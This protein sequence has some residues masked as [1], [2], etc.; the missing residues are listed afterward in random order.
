MRLVVMSHASMPQII[1]VTVNE[2]PS[3]VLVASSPDLPGVLAVALDARRLSISV[4]ERIRAWFEADGR[5]VQ[6]VREEGLVTS[7]ST[8]KVEPVP[9]NIRDQDTS[10]TREAC[11]QAVAAVATCPSPLGA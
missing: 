10:Q 11:E 2:E 1:R 6:V 8:W 4:P 3:G 7:L 5:A 9:L